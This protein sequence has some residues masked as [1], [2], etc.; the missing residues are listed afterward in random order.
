MKNNFAV[1]ELDLVDSQLLFPYRKKH[2]ILYVRTD[3]GITTDYQ[4]NQALGPQSCFSYG[5]C[6]N[7]WFVSISFMMNWEW[8]LPFFLYF[9]FFLSFLSFLSFFLSFFSFFLPSLSF[10]L[11]FFPFFPYSL[12]FQSSFRTL[13]FY[14]LYFLLLFY[15]LLFHISYFLFLI[16]SSVFFYN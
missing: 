1:Q 16:L 2:W 4:P 7:S 14:C 15:Y 11:S 3:R 5:N 12:S 13:L 8:K 10:F 6:V 9:F